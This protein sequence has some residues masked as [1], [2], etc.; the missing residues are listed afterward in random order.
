M[1]LLFALPLILNF[2]L[3]FAGDLPGVG[4]FVFAVVVIL[5]WSLFFILQ[6]VA[7]VRQL[8]RRVVDAEAIGAMCLMFLSYILAGWF[9]PREIAL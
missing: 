7:V 4:F 6:I 2:G 5:F 8:R 9:I 3:T 1:C